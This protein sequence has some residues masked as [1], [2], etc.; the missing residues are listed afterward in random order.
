ML[1]IA[2]GLTISS[3]FFRRSRTRCSFL[4]TVKMA[5]NIWILA[6]SKK[7]LISNDRCILWVVP[8]CTR[9]FRAWGFAVRRSPLKRSLI[10]RCSSFWI[11]G[12]ATFMIYQ[13]EKRKYYNFQNKELMMV[14]FQVGEKRQPE[15]GEPHFWSNSIE[16]TKRS[17]RKSMMKILWESLDQGLL[18]TTSFWC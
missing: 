7:V 1:V 18:H 5:M 15:H 8:G 3:S 9:S 6:P 17:L 11:R 12:L 16:S 10:K 14:L 4:R 2:W 13:K